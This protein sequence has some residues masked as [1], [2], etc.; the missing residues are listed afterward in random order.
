MDVSYDVLPFFLNADERYMKT[1]DQFNNKLISSFITAGSKFP[2][3]LW[4]NETS[5]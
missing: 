3:F 2:L 1:V 5:N 4:A